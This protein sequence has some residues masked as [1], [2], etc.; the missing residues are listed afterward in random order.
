MKNNVLIIIKKQLYNNLFV[1]Q[2]F[3][4]VSK[5]QAWKSSLFWCGIMIFFN[6][7]T[8]HAFNETKKK[9]RYWYIQIFL[10]ICKH[11]VYNYCGTHIRIWLLDKL[12]VINLSCVFDSCEI[13]TAIHLTFV[14]HFKL[15]VIKG[16]FSCHTKWHSFKK[17]FVAFMLKCDFQ[18]ND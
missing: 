17:F 4:I 3:L 11:N 9:Q 5:Y 14:F 13:H 15:K 12:S 8:P 16:T 10:N 6:T 2:D 7:W 1:E 18:L